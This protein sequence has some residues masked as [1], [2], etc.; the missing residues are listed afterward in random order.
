M[1]DKTLCNRFG[2]CVVTEPATFTLSKDQ[3]VEINHLALKDP[4]NLRDVCASKAL[5]VAGDDLSVDDLMAEIDK[6]I[7]F[8]RED[9]GCHT[10]GG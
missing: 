5:I 7:P 9:G 4:S 2:D 1:Y 10:F 6:D 8:Y 3:G